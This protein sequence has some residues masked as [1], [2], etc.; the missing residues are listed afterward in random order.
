MKVSKDLSRSE[1]ERERRKRKSE[2]VVSQG[3]R[4]KGVSVFLREGNER[5]SKVGRR[6]QGKEGVM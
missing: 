4:E 3:T 1:S 5:G 2:D 6:K